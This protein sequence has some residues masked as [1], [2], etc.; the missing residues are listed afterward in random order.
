MPDPAALALANATRWQTAK[1]TRN[2]T[3]IAKSLV[4]AK[5][6]VQKCN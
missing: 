3:S 4:A 6:K 1:L 2:V 5:A